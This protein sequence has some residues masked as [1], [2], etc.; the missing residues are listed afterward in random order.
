MTHTIFVECRQGND[1]RII[2]TIKAATD[3]KLEYVRVGI[4]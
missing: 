1:S 3:A 2:F 4:L